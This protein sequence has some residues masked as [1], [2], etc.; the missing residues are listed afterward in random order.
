MTTIPKHPI[1][2][3][4]HFHDLLLWLRPEDPRRLMLSLI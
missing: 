1:D 2:R 4:H 3:G